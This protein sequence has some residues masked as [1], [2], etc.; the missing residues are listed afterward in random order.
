[1]VGP[2]LGKVVESSSGPSEGDSKLRATC[3]RLADFPSRAVIFER[4]R[5]REMDGCGSF[6]ESAGFQISLHG[7][8]L[9][10]C[11]LCR[12]DLGFSQWEGET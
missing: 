12:R 7:P 9:K 4:G 8:V 11:P 5:V 10:P 6:P 1:M 2:I 3:A